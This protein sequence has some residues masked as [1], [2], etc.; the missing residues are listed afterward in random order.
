MTSWRIA[1][2]VPS[3]V[4]PSRTRCSVRGR[5]PTGPNIC[6]RSRMSFTGR[7]T[8]RAAMVARR[9]CDHAEP[10]QPKPPPR[11]G[12]TTRTFSGSMPS[13]FA[14][15]SFTPPTNCVAS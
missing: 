8:S 5:P 10:L 1:T 9:T 7:F 13:V 11:K 4:A 12:D 6:G 3:R 15:V 2:S 14:T